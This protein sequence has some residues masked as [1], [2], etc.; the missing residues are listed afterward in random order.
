MRTRV[1]DNK[2]THTVV[3]HIPY[4]LLPDARIAPQIRPRRMIEAFQAI[5]C[6]TEVVAGSQV[7]RR[8]RIR[9]LKRAVSSGEVV[10]DLVYSESAGWPNAL[11]DGG[12]KMNF[13]SDVRFLK[14]M[15]RRAPVA[16]FYRD[17]YHRS[18]TFFRVPFLQK[19]RRALL[20]L[21]AKN[22]LRQY[23]RYV[24]TLYLPSMAMRRVLPE[25][26]GLVRPLPPG[27]ERGAGAAM[28]AVQLP[29]RLLYVGGLGD[30]YRLHALFHAVQRSPNVRLVV[31]T[32]RDD[33]LRV[34]DEYGPY[35]RND[36]IEIVHLASAELAPL[37]RESHVAILTVQPN[38]YREFAV[39]VKLFEYIGNGMPILATAD[40]LAGRY[41]ST[42]ALG[43]A[44]AYD[45]DAIRER[46]AKLARPSGATEIEA[47]AEVV[48]AHARAVG[49]DSRARQVL[50]EH[51][52]GPQ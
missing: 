13:G 8:R 10:V 35:L 52:H 17:A 47:T 30:L 11:S 31:C 28:G 37:F 29:L 4:E 22:D 12:R 49:W 5:G 14:F 3:V 50:D 51:L 24:S 26:G 41:V 15:A 1:L 38:R 9:K 18:Q 23:N 7:E 16:L 43:W 19:L 45:V 48:S 34:R 39:P 32:R 42:H 40:T 21:L 33:W 44:V 20:F 2:S 36:R 25:F 6:R 27:A 46:L